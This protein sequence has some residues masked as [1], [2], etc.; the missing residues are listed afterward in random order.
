MF[1]LRS[2]QSAS[3][4]K[5]PENRI[6]VASAVSL[7]VVALAALV[8]VLGWGLGFDAW[9]RVLPHLSAMVP[10]TAIGLIAASIGAISID[11][12]WPM[13][14][15]VLSIA[16]IVLPI[17]YASIAQFPHPHDLP[18]DTM[19]LAA[20]FG[21]ICLALAILG[22]STQSKALRGGALA[23][24][25][26]SAL[27]C[28]IALLL[29]VFD[30]TI[31]QELAFFRSFAVHTALCIFALN[32][33]LILSDRDHPTIRGFLSSRIESKMA[34]AFVV[35]SSIGVIALSYLAFTMTERG[36]V[37]ANLRFAALASIMLLGL[38]GAALVMGYFI[39]RLERKRLRLVAIEQVASD[40][41]QQNKILEERAEHFRI[42]GQVVAGVAHDFNNSLAAVHGNLELIMVDSNANNKYVEAAISATNHATDLARQLLRSGQG[43]GTSGKTEPV[44]RIAARTVGL[45]SRLGTARLSVTLDNDLPE[46]HTFAADPVGLERALLNLLVNARDAMPKGGRINVSLTPADIHNDRAVHFNGGDG[47][48]PGEYVLITVADT[49]S[50]MDAET[51]KRATQ[52]Y[53]TTKGSSKGTGLGLSSVSG[54]CQEAGGGL[55]IE[56]TPD[57]GTT[58]T[59]A[60]PSEATLKQ[61][62]A[63]SDGTFFGTKQKEVLFLS[64]DDETVNDISEALA[65][66]NISVFHA[67]D[68]HAA[69]AHLD[70]A[71]LP[72]CILIDDQSF[73]H[74]PAVDFHDWVTSKYPSV[75][76]SL[77]SIEHRHRTASGLIV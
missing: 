32:G 45:F 3:T 59:M 25:M 27:A 20:R 16:G 66:R 56:S 63:T 11:Q 19:S 24:N 72:F 2:E 13:R 60:L 26:L 50:G 42:L 21:L 40:V 18:I 44:D 65:Q 46:G 23:L 41:E 73:G 28:L 75:T 74:G 22:R 7:C 36:V 68:F 33:A 55:R 14:W 71:P 51:L 43:D 49:G 39:D 47:M 77:L 70:S 67:H 35:A 29:H 1:A 54:F 48:L 57:R 6:P 4:R 30:A 9:K 69:E 62:S 61:A 76:V 52:P 58:I 15:R 37:P 12:Q 34:Q 10:E 64:P 17:V 53:F 8:L 5:G 38:F 31:L